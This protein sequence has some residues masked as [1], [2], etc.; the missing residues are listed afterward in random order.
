MMQIKIIKLFEKF[1]FINGEQI[2]AN[3]HYDK[4]W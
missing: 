2:Y 3:K 4:S 1:E